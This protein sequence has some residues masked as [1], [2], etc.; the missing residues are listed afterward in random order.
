MNAP[1]AL[2]TRIAAESA[3]A[4]AAEVA[5]TSAEF[6]QRMIALTAQENA[7]KIVRPL[8]KLAAAERHSM[9]FV[10]NE[11]AEPATLTDLLV[12]EAARLADLEYEAARKNL[13]A[14]AGI[15]TQTL[16]AE[17]ARLRGKQPGSN[18]AKLQG[19]EILFSPIEPWPE[20]VDGAGVLADVAR[21]LAAYVHLPDGATTAICLWVTAAHAFE[22][23]RHTPRINVTAA[24]RGCGKTLLLDVIATLAPRALRI[25]NMTQ[26]VLFR[27]VA[28]E[29]PTLLV[30]ECDR[31]LRNNQEL[32]GVLN[33]GFTQGGVVPRCE[34]DENKVRLFPVFAPVAL[35]GI[36]EL[37]GTLRDR[38]VIIRLERAT[39]GEIGRR[40]DSRH[41]EPE[42]ILRRKLMRWASDN[43]AELEA[44]DPEMPAAFNRVADVWRPLF[45]VAQ[46]AGGDWSSRCA[47]AFA[48][49]QMA[50][51]DSEPV[52]VQ[53]LQDVAGVMDASN[54]A[55][56]PSSVLVERLSA[57]DERAWPTW[58]HGH[59]I[60]Q[61]QVA[62]VLSGFGIKS[63][64]RRDG[65]AV[66][67][68]YRRSDF[69]DPLARYVSSVT[70]LQAA[71]EVACSDFASVT[72]RN[73]VTDGKTS[74]G[75]PAL[76]CNAVTD[77]APLLATETEAVL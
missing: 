30:D 71:P 13:A 8:R 33:A 55:N 53:L 12:R 16:D 27:I 2:Q 15:R 10:H 43:R 25:E 70:T 47:K 51:A 67:R 45:A 18:G 54:M 24:T 75:A 29:K 52:A 46:V 49:L 34:G 41:T 1:P 59:T 65:E 73:R 63:A 48:A 11:T 50:D 74:E 23:F 5:E 22:V 19:T 21:T 77:E 58:N 31:H 26:A 28:A 6:Q 7:G 9:R 32:I 68:G 39:P 57:M 62:R 14:N 35:A 20:P 4:Y 64:L 40:F 3:E 37:P 38:S 56:I 76:G 69:T 42:T 36:G 17:R 72:A 66:F 44:A 60:S 61:R